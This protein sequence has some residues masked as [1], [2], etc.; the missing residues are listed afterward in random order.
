MKFSRSLVAM[1]AGLALFGLSSCSL[2]DS[3]AGDGGADGGSPTSA[4]QG[5]GL[6]SFDPCTFF[7][8]DEL[9]S[10]GV[11]TQAK[12]FTQ[13]SFQPGCSWDG[14]R[15][16][17]ALQKNADDTVESLEKGGSYDEFTRINVAGR[18]SA[19]M[20]VAGGTGTGGCITVVPAGGGIVLY[21]L[22]G[23]MRDSVA[24]PCGEIEKIAG[25]TASRLPA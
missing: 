23:Y 1:S 22:S 7:K 12:D 17:V 10:Y 14:E 18:D 13:V 11:S 2:G 20:I 6:E 4:A 5:S 8:P 25:Q 16:S 15:L 24:D 3:S 9:T 21:Q 19:R